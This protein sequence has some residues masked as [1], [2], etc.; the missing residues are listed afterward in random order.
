MTQSSHEDLLNKW[1]PIINS[2]G[3]TGSKSDWMSQYCESHSN[4]EGGLTSSLLD[5][6]KQEEFPPL[7]PMSIRVAAQTIGLDL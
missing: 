2:V 1:A 3:L 7:L 6:C 5:N 4:F